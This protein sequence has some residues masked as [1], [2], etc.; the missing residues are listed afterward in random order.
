MTAP[1]SR[2][3]AVRDTDEN[4]VNLIGFGVY[5][6]D[7][8]RPTSDGNLAEYRQL[9]EQAI[10]HSD[11]SPIDAAGWYDTLVA[12]GEMTRADADRQLAEGEARAAASKAR[13]MSERV[14]EL[15]ERLLANPRIDLDD[16]TVVW[17]CECWW[18]AEERFDE[19]VGDR[20]V[21]TVDWPG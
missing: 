20:E 21:V 3:F 7:H 13:P 2:V 17:G 10:A 6:G 5:A 18:S 16:G 1:G 9:A 4:T 11:A 14:D 15:V 8:R 19:F 12:K